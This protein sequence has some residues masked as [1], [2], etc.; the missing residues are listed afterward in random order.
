MN[1]PLRLL[2][3]SM[4]ATVHPAHH[5]ACRVLISVAEAHLQALVRPNAGGNRYITTPS[6]TMGNDYC[7]A[8]NEQYPELKGVPKGNPDPKYREEVLSKMNKFDGSKLTRDLGIEYLPLKVT[9]ND[10]A[11]NLKEKFM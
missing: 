1:F 4:S 11:A 2:H 6:G 9:M 5:L 10:M 3:T 8:L 7:V